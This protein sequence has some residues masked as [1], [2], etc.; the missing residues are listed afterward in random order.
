MELEPQFLNLHQTLTSLH[1]SLLLRRFFFNF[2]NVHYETTVFKAQSTTAKLKPSPADHGKSEEVKIDPKVEE[3]LEAAKKVWT[4]SKPLESKKP[5]GLKRPTEAKKPETKRPELKKPEIKGKKPVMA[6]SSP[7]VLQDINPLDVYSV[8]S[9]MVNPELME[10][11]QDLKGKYSSS[12]GTNMGGMTQGRKAEAS[13]KKAFLTKL[14]KKFTSKNIRSPLDLPASLSYTAHKVIGEIDLIVNDDDII[15]SFFELASK[16]LQGFAKKEER[17]KLSKACFTLNVI[18]KS[19]R[20]IEEIDNAETASLCRQFND[21]LSA[22]IS[23]S[24]VIEK[25][26]SFV[27]ERNI[28]GELV[29]ACTREEIREA[30]EKYQKLDKWRLGN[31]IHKFV[32]GS[33]Q[34]T[35]SLPGLR[36]IH[37]LSCKKG[38]SFCTFTKI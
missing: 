13:A 2:L 31:E 21:L 38:R 32:Q 17:A 25:L 14:N 34:S 10:K 15:R 35:R 20:S 9:I 37:S 1:R 36:V 16:P 6:H 23:G 28:L 4:G 29:K 18:E 3:A 22:G 33:L 5:V 19:I 26:D 12:L 27:V 30:I 7:V 8:A 11:Y 24:E